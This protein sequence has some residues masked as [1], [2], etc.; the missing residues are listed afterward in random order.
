MHLIEDCAQSQGAKFK[1]KYVG[2]FGSF[3]CFLLSN[4]ILGGYG[5]ED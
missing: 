4:K 3:G 5:D 1:N 2:T